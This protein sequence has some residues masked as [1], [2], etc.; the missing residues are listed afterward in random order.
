M[1]SLVST[2]ITHTLRVEMSIPDWPS[3]WRLLDRRDENW[4]H[5]TVGDSES[6]TCPCSSFCPCLALLSCVTPSLHL[7]TS[8]CPRSERLILHK[9]VKAMYSW[10]SWSGENVGLRVWLEQDVDRV[11]GEEWREEEQVRQDSQCQ[12]D[13]VNSHYWDITHSGIC[14]IDTMGIYLPLALLVLHR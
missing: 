9:S 6:L 5:C 4:E 2:I 10:E 11:E 8:Y 1:L 12:Y 14:H 3:V 7:A 13:Q